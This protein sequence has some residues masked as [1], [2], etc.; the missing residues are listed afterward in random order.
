[1]SEE[2]YINTTSVCWAIT[3]EAFMTQWLRSI[4]KLSSWSQVERHLTTV[5]MP[6][7]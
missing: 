5:F 3:H 7:W 1:M 2:I 4:G 6:D